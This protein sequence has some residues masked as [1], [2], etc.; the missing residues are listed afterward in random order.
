MS[1][2]DEAHEIL[3]ALGLPKEQSNERSSLTLIALGKLSEEDNWQDVQMPC[4]RIVD[5]MDWMRDKLNKD[6]AP[7]SRETI[8]RRTIHQFEQARIVDRN[9]NEPTRPTN[10]GLTVYRLTD[11]IIRVIKSY[12]TESFQHEIEDFIQSH[13]S[14]SDKYNKMRDLNKVPVKFPD[15]SIQYMSPGEHN[16][17]QRLII[18]EFAPRFVKEPIVAYLGDTAEK[19]IIIN[20][21][22]LQ[23]L[24]IT[25]TEHD[26]LP[27]VIIYSPKTDWIFLIEAVTSHGPISPK[28]Y[29]ELEDMLSKC[30]CGR[31]YVTT[32]LTANDFRKYASDIVWESEVWI[33][34]A[35]DH[36]IHYNGDKFLGPH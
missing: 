13:G 25:V 27:D 17:L 28:R 4:M 7:N 2:I 1:K 18:E 35:P 24:N 23:S 19:H 29:H 11:N 32:F 22:L 26:K 14:L 10:S 9:P 12:G 15:D 21:N 16:E 3:V 5:I 34:E 33:A 30:T 8:R 31:V 36:M 6:Y 20:N